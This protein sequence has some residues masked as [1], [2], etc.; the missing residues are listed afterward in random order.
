MTVSHDKPGNHKY[1]VISALFYPND[2]DEHGFQ[3]FLKK[4]VDKKTEQRIYTP[5][6]QRTYTCG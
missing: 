6:P 3:I 2:T 1:S 5:R 4:F